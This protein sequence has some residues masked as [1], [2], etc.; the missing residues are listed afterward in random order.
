[1]NNGQTCFCQQPRPGVGQPVRRGGRHHRRPGAIPGGRTLPQRSDPDRPAGN[2]AAT[3][4]RR[5]LHRQRQGTKELASSWAVAG[6]LTSGPAGSSSPLCAP[7]WTTLTSSRARR[8]LVPSSRSPPTPMATTRCASRTTAT[9]DWRAPSGRPTTNG[10]QRW[11]DDRSRDRRDQS[12]YARPQFAD[13]DDQSQRSGRELRPGVPGVV[14][15]VPINLSL[16]RIR[17]PETR[18]L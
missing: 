3:G 12:L 15:A 13:I 1:M 14:S 5:G 6:R 10:G 17:S 7:T 4:P 18:A 9:T 8:S 11:P 2:R 16:T